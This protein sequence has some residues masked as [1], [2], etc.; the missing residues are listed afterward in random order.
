VTA[1]SDNASRRLLITGATGGM[2]QACTRQAAEQGYQL[3]LAD[4][5][6]E[7]LEALGEDC[8]GAAAAVESHVLDVT[9]REDIE[10]LVQ[11][12]ADGIDAVIH[13][14]GIS[15]TMADWEKIIDVDLI[16]TTRII[17][18]L[19]PHLRPEGAVVF[20]ASM[21]AHLCPPSAE[22]DSALST[23]LEAGLLEKLRDPAYEVIHDP[24][25]AYAYAKRA[26]TRYVEANALSWGREGKRLVSICPGLI[27]TA[28]GRQEREAQQDVFD[29]MMKMVALK[30]MGA[31]EEIASAALFLA[32]PAASYISGCDVLVDGGFVG[33]FRHQQA[34]RA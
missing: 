2:G 10:R 1:A 18:S 25:L 27:D 7:K 14:V 31:P 33:T 17:E 4:L 15:P 19:R 28:M 8:A 20:I 34:S 32:S 3:L 21:S 6:A 16:G 13:T 24:G 22:L 12:V 23:P 29:H 26:L 5:S 9:L 11:T 30:R